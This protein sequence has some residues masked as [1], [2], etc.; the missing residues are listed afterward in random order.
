[1][2]TESRAD[3]SDLV[4]VAEGII[5][6]AFGLAVLIWQHLTFRVLLSLLGAYIVVTGVLA[7]A[8][9]VRAFD[10]H[11]SWWR[12]AAKGIVAIAVGALVLLA[13]A[14]AGTILL[15]LIAVWALLTGIIQLA[16]SAR[17][18]DTLDIVSGGLLILFAFVVLIF[19]GPGILA[20]TWL[21]ALF[22]IAYGALILV[23]AFRPVAAAS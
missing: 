23:R 18:H 6:I 20:I 21:I 22:A 4:V 16:D 17:T 12:D 10:Q 8:N 1:M 7:L 5:A 11:T 3:R 14:I 19:A 9:A 15:Y 2:S 13:P